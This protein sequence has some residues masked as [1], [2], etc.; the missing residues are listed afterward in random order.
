MGVFGVLLIAGAFA[1]YRQLRP[2]GQA[3]GAERYPVRVRCVSCGHTVTLQLRPAQTFPMKCP[4][5]GE[6]TCQE[7]W[8]CLDCGAEFVPE[9]T[10]T[11]L[12]CP[13]CKSERVGSAAA[14]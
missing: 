4:K 10:G 9:Q 11:R 5:C 1:L 13:E 14:P 3:D 6:T 8:K 2:H 12:R 7:L